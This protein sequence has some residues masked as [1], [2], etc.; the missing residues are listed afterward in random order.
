MRRQEAPRDNSRALLTIHHFPTKLF[1]T[2]QPK[3]PNARTPTAPKRPF[4]SSPGGTRKVGVERK[5]ILNIALERCSVTNSDM[6]QA[7]S[8]T[9]RN[10][11][12]NAE[13][14]LNAVAAFTDNVRILRVC[15]PR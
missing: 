1:A 9:T 3:Q 11:L 15:L 5:K 14:I 6:W 10:F 4:T 2:L 13:T 7:I 8:Q 12:P